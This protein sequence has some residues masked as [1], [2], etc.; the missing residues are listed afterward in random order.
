[1][2]RRKKKPAY[3][4]RSGGR[5]EIYASVQQVLRCEDKWH[6]QAKRLGVMIAQE[7]ESIGRIEN[8][9]EK[10]KKTTALDRLYNAYLGWVS[11]YNQIYQTA[12]EKADGLG[13]Q[14]LAVVNKKDVKWRDLEMELLPFTT[15]LASME[16]ELTTT[17]LDAARTIMPGVAEY[18]IATGTE[19]D[20]AE[21]AHVLEQMT[22]EP[23][24]PQPGFE[25]VSEDVTREDRADAA[26]QAAAQ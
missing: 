10:E 1:M 2:S 15:D 6:E 17:L 8:E 19:K 18:Q 26:F 25:A 23:G 24:V 12:S 7:R 22:A 5:K 9:A 21:M 3:N 4:P 20:N 16:S 13:Q 11:H 14:A